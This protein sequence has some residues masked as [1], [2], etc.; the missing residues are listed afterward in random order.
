MRSLIRRPA[1]PEMAIRRDPAPSRWGYRYQRMMLTPLYRNGMRIGLPILLVALIA[2]S[3]FS[4]EANRKMLSD[5]YAEAVQAIHQRPEFMVASLK[6]EGGTEAL[7]TE[8]SALVNVSFPV[9]SFDLD[10]AALRDKIE[11]VPAVQGAVVGVQPGGVLTVQVTP[12]VPVAI[13]RSEIG[14]QMIDA[15]GAT[16]GPLTARSD[17]LDLPLIAGDGAKDALDEAMAIYAVAGPIAPRVRGLV[18]MGERRWDVVLDR[19]QR[20]LLPTEAPVRAFERVIAM[21]QAEDLLAREVTVV[22]FRNDNR[23][24]IRMMEPAVMEMRR[25]N[26]ALTGT[27]K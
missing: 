4:H 8:V 20:I 5:T 21:A 1:A 19:D 7:Q 25:I 12:R 18:R 13:W 16:V 2:L 24:T 3:W 11:A 6:V 10:L 22:D 27:G 26:A 17:R 14:L 9:S 15:A 23:P